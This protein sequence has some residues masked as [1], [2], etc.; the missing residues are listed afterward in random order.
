[1]KATFRL[2]VPSPMISF[3]GRILG[4]VG[5]IL[6]SSEQDLPVQLIISESSPE[7]RSRTATWVTQRLSTPPSNIYLSDGTF[8]TNL[9]LKL[10]QSHTPKTTA[11]LGL[12]MKEI[13]L[14]LIPQQISTSQDGE[15][16][17]FS[18]TKISR[19]HLEIPST[20]S[21]RQS[22]PVNDLL[23]VDVSFSIVRR[24]PT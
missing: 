8:P 1:M 16:P 23:P 2:V 10:S 3:I 13:L 11:R 21:I 9:N 7:L 19:T 15:I 4:P 14:F 20:R 22:R 12:N 5:K 17:S 6:L 24:I 18:A